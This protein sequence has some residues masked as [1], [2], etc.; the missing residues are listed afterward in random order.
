LRAGTLPNNLPSLD[1]ALDDMDAGAVDS[2]RDGV[3]DLDEL[4]Q[5]LSPNEGEAVPGAAPL[6]QIP[7]PRTGC[8]L[9]PAV[10]DP[11]AGLASALSAALLL[12]AARARRRSG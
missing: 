10:P 1:A 6:E 7:L 12:L 3:S 8:A 2:D 5:N 4:R 11:T 9:R